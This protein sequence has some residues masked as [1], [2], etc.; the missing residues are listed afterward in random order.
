MP[1]VLTS[2]TERAA[3]QLAEALVGEL[4]L[5]RAAIRHV[6]IISHHGAAFARGL[7][8]RAASREIS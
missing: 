3:P 4:M 1:G 5:R 2:R 6:P 8:E 7:T